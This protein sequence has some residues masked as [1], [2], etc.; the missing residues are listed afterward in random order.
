VALQCTRRK[1]TLI[2]VVPDGDRVRLFGAADKSL[3]GKTVSIVF[4]ATHQVVATVR[5]DADGSFTTTAPLPAAGVRA[6]N[7]ARYIAEAGGEKSLKLKLMRRMV[8][9]RIY[10]HGRFVTIRG[11]VVAPLAATPQTITLKRRVT[12]HRLQVVKRFK[13]LSDG[14]FTVTVR[15]PK[16]LAATVYRLQ[17]RVR[18][19]VGNPKLYPTFTLPRAVDL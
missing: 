19:S 18:Q 4:E 1:L 16:N 2:D 17:T 5:V 9:Q 3:A 14:S 13:P 11:R 7:R 10:S 15:K 12:C 6:T 8:V